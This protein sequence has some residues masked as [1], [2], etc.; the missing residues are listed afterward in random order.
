MIF[1]KK[2]SEINIY[3]M[4]P[5]THIGIYILILIL[6]YLMYYW[7]REKHKQRSEV[8]FMGSVFLFGLFE[9]A[10][11]IIFAFFLC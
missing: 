6:T 1:K 5:L 10:Y 7:T 4:K 2:N 9:L 11:F 8:V 3:N